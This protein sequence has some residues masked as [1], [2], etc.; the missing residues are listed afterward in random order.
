MSRI[1]KISYTNHICLVVT[2]KRTEAIRLFTEWSMSNDDGYDYDGTLQIGSYRNGK[3]KMM[4]VIK[5]VYGRYC[6]NKILL[7]KK[8]Y[9]NGKKI[10]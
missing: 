10:S 9:Q 5:K 6:K 7:W 8:N 1:Y 2:D 4:K 3:D